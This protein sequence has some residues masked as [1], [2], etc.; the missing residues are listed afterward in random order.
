M[1]KKINVLV[2]MKIKKLFINITAN[3]KLNMKILLDG[4]KMTYK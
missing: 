3:I 2:M 4:L 1:F